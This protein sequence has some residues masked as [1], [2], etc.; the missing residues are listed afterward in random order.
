MESMAAMMIVTVALTSFIGLLAYSELAEEKSNVEIDTHFL[1]VLHID[2]GKIEGDVTGKLT[3]LCEKNDYS[4]ID[5]TVKTVD[6]KYSDT[7]FFTFGNC[8]TEDSRYFSGRLN[9]TTDSGETVLAS[10]EMVV[11]L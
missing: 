3:E 1:D 2:R 10:Y 5:L 11:F 8:A 7:K 6:G 9:M 4:R